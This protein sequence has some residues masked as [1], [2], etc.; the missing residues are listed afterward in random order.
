M[1]YPPHLHLTKHRRTLALHRLIA[2]K[3]RRDPLLIDKARATLDRWTA[4]YTRAAVP[5]YITGWTEVLDQG[6]EVTL[7]FMV[8][9]GEHA[10][11]LRQSSPFAGALTPQER[12]AFLAEWREK[13]H[14]DSGNKPT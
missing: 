2:E 11:E 10:T 6:L 9:E 1:D 8:D 5:Y 7:A 13:M 14:S 12:F 3:V 4:M